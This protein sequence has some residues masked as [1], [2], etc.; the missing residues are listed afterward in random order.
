M[1]I[2]IK[3]YQI[4]CLMYDAQN[5]IIKKIMNKIHWSL[6]NQI[7]QIEKIKNKYNKLIINNE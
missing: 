5:Q 6:E 3:I 2:Q 4:Q 7:F 1:D